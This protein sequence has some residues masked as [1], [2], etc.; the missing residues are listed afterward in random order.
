M[1]VTKPSLKSEEMQQLRLTYASQYNIFLQTTY[2]FLELGPMLGSRDREG[3]SRIL[4][5][6]DECSI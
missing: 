1:A 4:L 2:Y 5:T 3:M 6:L